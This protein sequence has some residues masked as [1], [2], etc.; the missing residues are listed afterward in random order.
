MMRSLAEEGFKEV[1]LTGIHLGKYGADLGDGTD[2][3]ALLRLAGRE[4][5]PLRVRLS[6]LEPGEIDREL[7]E[8]VASETWLCRHFHIPLQ[9]GDDK[10]LKRMNR[11]YT[12]RGFA[13]LVEQ[14]HRTIPLAAIGVDIMAGFPGE[15]ARAFENGHALI[16]DLPASYLHVFPYSPRTG[17][18]AARFSRQVHP[19]VA[20]E[21][22][23][24]LRRLGRAKREHFYGSCLGKEF[25]VLAEGW[26]S[27]EEGLVKGLSDNYVRVLFP[28]PEL[29]KNKMVRVR[30]E[31]L[32]D[33]GVVGEEVNRYPLIR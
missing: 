28:S 22:A 33:N 16:R 14:I 6:S 18:P 8:M 26:E 3:K 7:I 11:A 27:G 24:A 20:K 30:M 17:T 21:R 15:D 2:L 29:V 19:E 13:R 10:I 5:L 23:A 25:M 32:G 31:S 4:Q 9:S 12:A 1:V